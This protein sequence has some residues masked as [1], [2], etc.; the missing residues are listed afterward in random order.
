MAM[1]LGAAA[2]REQI[3]AALT[4]IDTAHQVLR[5][6]SSDLVGNDF[7]VEVAERL[8]FQDRINRG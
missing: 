8:E 3:C 7:R 4:A 2:A 5:E 1:A 6:T